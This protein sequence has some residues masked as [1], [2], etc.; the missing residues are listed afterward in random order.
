MVNEVG[1]EHIHR[2]LSQPDK[3]LYFAP[4][5]HHSPACAWAVQQLIRAVKP[6]Q[7]LIEA[8]VD[9]E[10]HIDVLLDRDTRPPIAIAAL[11][12]QQEQARLAAYYPFCA[13]SPE[14]IALKTGREL[15]A[16]LSFI[17]LPSTDKVLS[18]KPENQQAINLQND[19]PF[20]SGDYI[21][22]LTKQMGCRDGYELWDHLFETRLGTDDWQSFFADVGTYCAGIRAA[23]LEEAII[24]TGDALREQHMIA[25]LNKALQKKG[26]VVVVIGGFHSPALIDGV[27]NQQTI[28]LPKE[29]TQNS[30]SYVIRYGFEALDALNG[31][32]AGLPQP[33]YYDFLWQ[34]AEKIQG[35][36]LWRETALDLV[37]CFTEA[38]CKQ[39]HPINVPAQVE[40]LR[41]AETLALMRNRP[42]ILRYDLIDGARVALVKGETGIRDVWTE[43]LLDFLCG[44]AIG[45]VSDSAGLPPIVED[46]RRRAAKHRINLEDGTKRQRKLDIRRKTTHLAASQYFHAMGLLETGFA[47]RQIGPDYLNNVR[48]ELLFEEWS[49]AWSPQ[50]ESRLIELAVLGDQINTACIG[51]LH[52]C[53]HE[54]EKEG[55]GRDLEALCMLL[56]RGLLAGLGVELNPFLANISHHIQSHNNFSSIVNAL[57]RLHYL[58][59]STGPIGAPSDLNLTRVLDHAYKRLIYLCD[60]IASTPEEVQADQIEA[61]RLIAELLRSQQG[62]TY[63]VELFDN[64]IDR[65]V[66]DNPPAKILGAV[67]AIC[68]QAGRRSVEELGNT[69]L[70]QFS[71]SITEEEHRISALIGMLHTVP[72]LLWRE[73]RLLEI[74]DQF[75]CHLSEDDFIHLLPHLR[76]AFTAYNPRETD[77]LAV[78]LGKMHNTQATAFTTSSMQLTDDDLQRGL[79]IEQALRQ[80]IKQDGLDSWLLM[81]DK[82]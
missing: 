62:Y 11:I 48:T 38:M 25:L 77:R 35:A 33:G 54:L 7:I 71:G 3:G 23:T 12:E 49:Y 80:S 39:G 52:R 19:K 72:A 13:H 50:I 44:T 61:L 82:A 20:N 75:L 79:A 59:A 21:A 64:A 24:N 9:F 26:P 8:P 40:M 67:L 18:G 22:A 73:N 16:K 10:K 63:D 29:S 56:G 55:Q 57:R 2:A 14:F 41:S 74:V 81:E 27:A 47:E 28:S 5:R 46:A 34:R 65:I 78:Q 76:L 66:D 43:R 69:L 70:G 36:P 1:M 4:I 15:G 32:A 53:S 42:G 51:F 45:N 60:D 58:E 6:K 37:S 68:V 31:Y 17:D 30:Q